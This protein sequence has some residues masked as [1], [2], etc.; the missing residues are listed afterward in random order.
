[1]QECR[2]VSLNRLSYLVLDEADTMLELGFE[3]QIRKIVSQSVPRKCQ[4]L[5]FCAN[6]TSEIDRLAREVLSHPVKI[7]IG[8]SPVPSITTSL[9]S[10]SVH[11]CSEFEKRTLILQHIRQIFEDSGREK[12]GSDEPRILKTIIFTATKGTADEVTRILRDANIMA[13]VIHGDK[14]LAERDWVLGEFRSG[15]SQI[16][17]ATEVVARG[18][19]FKDLSFIINYD[20]P[21]TIEDYLQRMKRAGTF[22]SA[23]T[24]ITYFTPDSSKLTRELVSVLRQTGQPVDSRLESMIYTGSSRT[25]ISRSA[26]GAL[27]SG[28]LR[29]PYE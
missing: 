14:S 2:A 9:V 25:A 12:V 17:V 26:R 1:M 29:L 6:W 15:R 28:N 27:S 23:G 5:L 7:S 20:M 3:S 19:D 16:M 8:E 24:V 18:I 4:K 22:R 11:V 21:R 13:L 10:Q